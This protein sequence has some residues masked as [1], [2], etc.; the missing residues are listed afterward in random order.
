MKVM[1]RGVLVALVI[2]V[3][4][5]AMASAALASLPELSPEPHSCGG[6]EGPSA[7]V[8][9]SMKG[10]PGKFATGADEWKY[11]SGSGSGEFVASEYLSFRNTHFTLAGG[12][13]SYNCGSEGFN[14]ASNIVGRVGIVG[15]EAAGLLLEPKSGSL[16]AKCTFLG[17]PTEVTGA[18]MASISPV[19][20]PT[21]S[22]TVTYKQSSAN[23]EFTK[24]E[25]ED[26]VHD[27]LFG[28]SKFGLESTLTMESFEQGGKAATVEVNTAGNAATL[29]TTGEGAKYGGGFR[30]QGEKM[31]FVSKNGVEVKCPSFSGTGD[32]SNAKEGDVTL[33]LSECTGPLK[34]KCEVSAKELKALLAYTYP[35]KEIAGEREAALVLSPASGGIFAEFD[36]AGV[37]SVVTGSLLS[38]VSPLGAPSKVFALSLKQKEGAEEGPSEY[39]VSESG[40]GTEAKLDTSIEG[41]KPE[42]SG[43]QVVLPKIELNGGGE[44]TIK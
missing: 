26:A 32:F 13:G 22:L 11:T 3:A 14:T 34:T 15:K 19:N 12:G 25:G 39:E 36:C 9:F 23:Q 20:T 17:S 40:K 2:A 44:E 42:Q 29:R 16:F 27:L 1:L 38:V 4:A 6:C 37:K 30:V 24:F 8:T 28:G 43:L 41:G 21:S 33:G 7:P 31:V 5:G 18:V 10:G 35:A